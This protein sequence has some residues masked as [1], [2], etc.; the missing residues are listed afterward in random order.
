MRTHGFGAGGESEEGERGSGFYQLKTYEKKTAEKSN[1][2]RLEM[3]ESKKYAIKR[4]NSQQR[5][6]YIGKI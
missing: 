3:N 1:K 4:Y 2:T 5:F 6:L